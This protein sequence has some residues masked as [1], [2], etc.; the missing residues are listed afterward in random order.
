MAFRAENGRRVKKGDLLFETIEGEFAGYETDLT[1]IKA[2]ADGVIGSL[3]VALGGSVT[4][5][6][7]ICTLYPDDQLRVE[8]AVNEEFLSAMPVGT[9]VQVHFT[10][11]GGGEYTVGGTVEQVSAAGY[12]D[13]ESESDEAFFKAIVKLDDISGVSYGMTVT[14]VN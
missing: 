8:A 9:A 13:E 3:S 2:P 5:G 1:E 7:M 11:V 6:D 14:V 10:Y 4:A 12:T